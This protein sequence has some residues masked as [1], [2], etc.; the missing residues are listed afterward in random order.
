MGRLLFEFL[1]LRSR[2]RGTTR[3]LKGYRIASII[4]LLYPL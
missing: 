3:L 4:I 2:K 1:L